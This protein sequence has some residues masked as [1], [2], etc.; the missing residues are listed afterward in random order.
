[1]AL[2]EMGL[3][4]V[5]PQGPAC[6]ALSSEGQPGARQGGPHRGHVLAFCGSRGCW[7]L[8]QVEPSREKTPASACPG[9]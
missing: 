9:E 8:D 4:S 5:E 2:K 6:K 7:E 3:M 1:M